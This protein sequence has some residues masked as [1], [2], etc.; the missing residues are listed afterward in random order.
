MDNLCVEDNS[1]ELDFTSTLC[2]LNGLPASLFR[3]LR[4]D[5]TTK[6][7]LSPSSQRWGT[8]PLLRL[9]TDPTLLG[10]AP[11]DGCRGVPYPALLGSPLEI[12]SLLPLQTGCWPTG[13]PGLFPRPPP[14]L[15]RP[16]R[17]HPP[18]C[19]VWEG[20]SEQVSGN[21][22]TDTP[23]RWRCPRLWTPA[24]ILRRT[25]APSVWITSWSETTKHCT[26]NYQL[27]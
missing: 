22:P 17:P 8:F 2:R 16:R 23:S 4:P 18:K 5:L 3:P 11:M 25:T 7:S 20:T 1:T 6:T 27:I 9:Q 21:S 19:P 13:T 12:S 14:P 26:L 15:P 24:Q 10:R